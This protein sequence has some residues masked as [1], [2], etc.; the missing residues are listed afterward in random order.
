MRE[1]ESQA[2][3]LRSRLDSLA[4]FFAKG[5]IDAQQLT[6]GT[7]EI[8]LALE[9]VRTKISRNLRRQWALAGVVDAED[10]GSAWLEAPLRPST[11]GIGCPG[12]GDAATGRTRPPSRL[13]AG[14]NVFPS[15]AGQDRMDAAVSR[16]QTWGR[17]A[18]SDAAEI[19]VMVRCQGNRVI[20]TS[21]R[22]SLAA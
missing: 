13:A 15:G 7:K 3:A 18:R 1:L 16:R 5:V 14:T 12:D 20:G 2:V 11:G 10:A 21:L 6:E 8:N 9:A 17:D 22:A 4:G 19:Q